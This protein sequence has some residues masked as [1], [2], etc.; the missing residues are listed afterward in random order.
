MDTDREG[1]GTWTGTRTGT[2][3]WTGTRTAKNTW[4]SKKFIIS[5]SIISSYSKAKNE[6]AEN[7]GSEVLKM[8]LQTSVKTAIAE[9]IS[10][11]SCGIVIVE[12]LP[13]GCGI[14]IGDSKKSCAC[15]PVAT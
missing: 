8:K 14:G 9:Q 12:A 6:I 1:I 10:L 3:T 13:S 7:C 15:P 4:R 2:G 5:I 11:N